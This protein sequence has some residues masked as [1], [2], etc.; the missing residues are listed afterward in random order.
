MASSEITLSSGVGVQRSIADTGRRFLAGLELTPPRALVAAIRVRRAGHTA[1][2]LSSPAH[3]IV[4][5]RFERR[6]SG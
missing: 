6:R 2:P 5:A 3:P 1:V 4:L